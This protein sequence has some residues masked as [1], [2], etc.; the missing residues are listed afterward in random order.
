MLVNCNELSR[1]EHKLSSAFKKLC[2]KHAPDLNARRF[3]GEMVQFVFFARGRKCDTAISQSLLIHNEGL[4]KSFSNISVALRMYLSLIASNC[5]GKRS[6]SKLAIIKNKLR[7]T[8]NDDRLSALGIMSIESDILRKISFEGIIAEFSA[9]KSHKC[10]LQLIIYKPTGLL[11][12]F[13]VQNTVSNQY[14][15]SDWNSIVNYKLQCCHI[16]LLVT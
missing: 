6:I 9:K 3:A 12:F 14:S 10:Q 7:T 4:R 1:D 13:T 11:Q 2:Q 5:T 15:D 16:T 8:M